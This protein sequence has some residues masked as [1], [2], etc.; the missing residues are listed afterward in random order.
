MSAG[1]TIK[2]VSFN[3]DETDLLGWV[4]ANAGRGG[5]SP[6]IKGLIRRAMRPNEVDPAIVNVIER[7]VNERLGR[8][9]APPE[10]GAAEIR[11]DQLKGLF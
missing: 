8:K 10:G 7:L 3:A 6:F 5:F 11:E 1:R 4:E 2:T 9:E